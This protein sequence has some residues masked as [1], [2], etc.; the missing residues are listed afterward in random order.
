MVEEVGAQFYA[1]EGLA[2]PS[3]SN[4]HVRRFKVEGSLDGT[5][6]TQI[7]AFDYVQKPFEI[8]EMEAKIEKALEEGYPLGFPFMNVS[9]ELWDGKSHDV[10]SSEMAFMEAARLA[11]RTATEMVGVTILEPIMKVVVT[12]P[13]TNL[14]DV[15]GSLSA[16]RGTLVSTEQGAGDTKQVIAEVPLAEMF[17]YSTFLRGMTQG[18]GNYTME[19]CKYAAAP[20]SV[21]LK[22]RKEVEDERKARN[23]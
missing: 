8:E 11:V 20:E 9:G 22:I 3:P 10:D 5:S 15:L 19:P 17:Q 2:E 7:G 6:Y 16:R 4:I 13:D 23:K 14:G 21:A 12:T 18:R 1:P